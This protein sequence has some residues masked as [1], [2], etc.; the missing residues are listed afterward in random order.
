MGRHTSPWPLALCALGLLASAALAAPGQVD[1]VVPL[2]EDP[3]EQKSQAARPAD[4]A[5][6][7]AK[8]GRAD[9]R[10]REQA[11]H[12]LIAMGEAARGALRAAARST[13]AEVRWRAGY[14]LSRLGGGLALPK[15]DR[16]RA[17]YAS[18][19]DARAQDG[20]QDVARLL[21]REAAK[22]FPATRW[23]AAARERLAELDPEREPGKAKEPEDKVI[24][25][26]VA[27]LGSPRW[28]ERQEASW[29]LAQLGAAATPALERAAGGGDG[30]A[31]WRAKRLLER[32]AA[33]RVTR[34]RA[35]G[36]L[37]VRLGM[38]AHLLGE[39]APSA[40]PTD[41]DDLVRTLASDDPA[42][43]AH[44]R[45]VLLNLGPDAVDALMRGLDGRSEVAGVE[46]MDLLRRAT[47]K[48]LGFSAARWRAWWR[49]LHEGRED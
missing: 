16:A 1:G 26:L 39:S 19:A 28:A 46:I 27:Q 42:E 2:G 13:D 18:A 32:T 7:T 37:S 45:E 15:A 17:L 40:R 41:M 12:A 48:K 14:A 20:A 24:A 30:E 35:S 29:R 43:V 49:A 10:V 4:L 31:A 5:A 33:A 6:L 25:R 9:W 8:L 47:G 23:A 3:L 11:M 21:Y 36:G 44:A 22:R 34:T 38:M